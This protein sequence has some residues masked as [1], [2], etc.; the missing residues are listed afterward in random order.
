MIIKCYYELEPELEDETYTM[1]I[2]I[3]DDDLDYV[4]VAKIE[5]LFSAGA[6][7]VI[8]KLELR[9]KEAEG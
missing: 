8:D 6:E 3:D 1:G 4:K 5:M 2:Y 9:S 7:T